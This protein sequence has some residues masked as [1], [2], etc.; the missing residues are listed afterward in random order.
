MKYWIAVLVLLL[1]GS[2]TACT[3]RTKNHTASSGVPVDAP[4]SVTVSASK[5]AQQPAGAAPEVSSSS[6]PAAEDDGDALATKAWQ[7]ILANDTHPIGEYTPELEE[8]QN[9]YKMDVRV[10]PIMR[11]MIADASAQ[12][13]ELLVCSAYRPYSSQE[14]N[15]NNSVN[16]YIA[17]GYSKADAI[18]WTKRYI[19]EPGKSEH[20]T[21]LAADI[22]TPAYQLL[23]DGYANTAAAQWLLEHA[24]EYGFILRYPKDKTEITK[25]NFEPWHYRYVGPE[26][27]KEIHQKGMCLE[28]YLGEE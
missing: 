12:G 9:G 11:Q 5:A 27:A 26:V 28:E 4:S 17:Q 24:P 15:F 21:G 6:Q 10:A 20:Q 8:V 16:S 19:M 1:A 25:V 22:V 13:V 7:L 2:L 14:R 18:A 23:N 3:A